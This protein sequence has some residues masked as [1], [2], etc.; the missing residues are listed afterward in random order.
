MTRL[1]RSRARSR[2][3]LAALLLP[4]AVSPLAAVDDPSAVRLGREVVPTRAELELALDPAK[5]DY[6]GTIVFDVEVERPVPS[7]RLH[8]RGETI[9]R[10]AIAGGGQDQPL[11]VAIAGE[12]ATFT[13]PQRLAAGRHRLTIEFTQKVDT[14]AVALYRAELEGTPYLYTQFEATEAREAFPCFDQPD[15]KL[16]W[17]IA[18]TV[19]AGQSAVANSPVASDAPAVAGHC[20]VFAPTPPLPSYLIALAVGPFD[21]V[22]VP[23]T[24]IPTRV[25]APKGRGGLAEV[26]VRETPPALRALEQWFGRPYPFA[27]LDLLAV[28][29][30]AYGAMENPGAITFRDDVLL[31]DAARMS[32]ADLREHVITVTHELAHMW[33]GDLVTMAWWDDLW[34]NESFADWLS[35]RIT[36]QL[37]PELEAGL[38]HRRT[39]DNVM[40]GDARASALPIRQDPRAGADAAM[41]NIGTIYNKGNAVLTMI[42]GWLGEETFQRGVRQYLDEHAGG[43]ATGPDLWR[44][45]G[46]ASRADVP[47]VLEP[48][49]AQAGLP[50][51][52]AELVGEGSLHLRQRRFHVAGHPLPPL[53]WRVPMVV[54]YRDAGG[55]RTHR[56]LLEGEE[57]TVELP[58]QGAI[59]WLDP[60]ASAAGYY[61]WALPP[62]DFERLL[63]ASAELEPAER[64][65]LVATA[66]ALLSAGL[67]A[68]D[69]Y[70]EIATRL[71]DDPSPEVGRVAVDALAG[72]EEAFVLPTT[73]RLYSLFLKKVLAPA[74]ARGGWQ[75]APGEAPS[76]TLLRPRLLRLAGDQGRD[77]A[78][79]AEGTR[80]A[81][82][83]LADRSAVDPSM[84]STVL[85]LAAIDGGE[86]LY[87]ELRRAYEGSRLPTEKSDLLAALGGF[88]RPEIQQEA[89]AYSLTDAVVS[90]DTFAIG[91]SV[92]SD[93]AGQETLF[94]WTLDHHDQLLQ[95]LPPFGRAFLPFV[96]DG[97]SLARLAEA[98]KFFRRPEHFNP[99]TERVLAK[100]SDSVHQCVELAQRE[101]IVVN[102]YFAR[103]AQPPRVTPSGRRPPGL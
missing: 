53:A 81:R 56:L 6:R 2:F 50:V 70:V 1:R 77:P 42:E 63:A 3:G 35:Y 21:F 14:Q 19:P 62:A 97:C 38:D 32:P 33:F 82:A 84:V 76:L 4:L 66:R 61:R 49:I 9:T 72:L 78:L 27:K 103:I 100:V 7:F 22:A 65:Q 39:L 80:L 8:V 31:F 92:A 87:Q 24:S 85:W 91:E 12:V 47:G 36:D 90:T 74:I 45:L 99:S 88:R 98:E 95:R 71:V 18:L 15:F 37:H 57:A 68:G 94:R 41:Q 75:P 25:V 46:K 48:W 59:A 69:R 67:L 16:P 55:I 79:R 64:M 58:H 86:D 83:W 54:R 43:N 60:S 89:L 52:S 102:A 93:L 5:P 10:A 34:L 29:E 101:S 28:P 30:F 20:V 26:A 96:A 40:T 23:G 73:G 51:V 17:T 11:S 13:P 44:A